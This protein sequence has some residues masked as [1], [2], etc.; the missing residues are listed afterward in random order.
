MY[1]VYVCMIRKRKN[2]LFG[3]FVNA[4]DVRNKHG[5]FTT[6]R[7]YFGKKINVLRLESLEAGSQR[8]P[9]NHPGS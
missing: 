6:R 2:V 9:R 4:K 8:S 1:D 7:K 5:E 3:C